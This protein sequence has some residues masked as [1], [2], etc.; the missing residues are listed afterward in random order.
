MMRGPPEDRR[1]LFFAKTAPSSPPEFVELGE[2]PVSA[3][4]LLHRTDFSGMIAH[5]VNGREFMEMLYG[6]FYFNMKP[7]V[8]RASAFP[9]H[10]HLTVTA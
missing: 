9:F 7:A 10:F 6:R 2:K 8:F 5:N 3:N 4:S 1:S